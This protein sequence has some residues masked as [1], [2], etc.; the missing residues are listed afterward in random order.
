MISFISKIFKSITFAVLVGLVIIGTG[1]FYF[2]EY[3]APTNFPPTAMISVTQG[4][5][6]N[7]I[8]RELQDKHVVHS[9]FWLVNFVIFLKH[10]RQ[11]V[12]GDYYFNRPMNVYQVA[13]R[14]T[15]GD[16]QVE[17]IKTTIPEG[18]TVFDISDIMLKN[19][20][21]F[22]SSKFILLAKNKEGYLFPDTYK[23]GSNVQPEKVLQVMTD[24]FNKKIASSTVQHAITSFGKPLNE[25]LTM[26]SI[27]EG[28]ARLTRTRQIVA[29]ILWNRIKLGIPL[30]VDAAFRYVN[31]KTTTVL[32]KDDLR[33]DSPYNTYIHTGLTPTPI[34]NPGLDSIMTAVTPIQTDYIYFLTDKDGNMHYAKTLDEHAINVNKYLK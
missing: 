16:F 10:E 7:A 19:Y 22:D 18:V 30:Q 13:K 34:S 2:F 9:Q 25:V 11:I 3:R 21:N 26:A 6:L 14:L 15:S 4:K 31:G 27:L 23:F 24:N 5:G 1:Y 29:G 12:S 33:I 20:P 8:A 32:T 17:Q 28:E